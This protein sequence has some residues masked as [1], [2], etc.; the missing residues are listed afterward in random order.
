[1]LCVLIRIA[2]YTQHT[3][4][5]IK[6]QSPKII[7]NTIVSAAVGLF[8]LATHEQ[9]RNSCGKSVF[10]PLKFAIQWTLVISK[11]K[12]PSKPLR[13]I[14]TSTYQICSIE[15]KRFEQQN[16]TNDYVI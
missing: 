12:G 6:R 3:I 15:A 7:P 5:N 4:I 10:G 9:V 2:S 1:M 16:F 11:W 14:R 13:D 8:W